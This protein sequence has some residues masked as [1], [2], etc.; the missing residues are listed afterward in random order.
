MKFILRV[1]EKGK[2]IEILFTKNELR[3]FYDLCY[4]PNEKEI[5][6]NKFKIPFKKMKFLIHDVIDKGVCYELANGKIKNKSVRYLVRK[7]K[8]KI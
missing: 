2:F 1:E 4:F 5:K 6:E 3:T 8:W 7:P